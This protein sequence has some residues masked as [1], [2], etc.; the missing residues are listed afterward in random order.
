M[1]A[2]PRIRIKI[3]GIRDAA[4]ARQTALAGA[5]AIGLVFVP[6]TPRYVPSTAQAREIL[7]AL[8]PFCTPVGL[9]V[10]APD[11]LVRETAAATGLT[12][13][14]LHGREGPAYAAD[15]APLRV[16]KAVGFS[17]PETAGQLSQWRHAPANVVGL[18]IDAPPP[19]APDVTTTDIKD[20][21]PPLQ[22]GGHGRTF[23]W[24]GLADMQQRGELAGLPPIILAGGLT[25]TNVAQAI[26]TV[27][28]Y[29]V[30]VSSG[31]ERNKGEK[32]MDLIHQFIDAVNG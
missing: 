1:P 32:D 12:T 14:Q 29:A 28:P 5:D 24:Q 30:D 7:A 3:C 8:P 27:R 11:K 10:D 6:E 16:I 9:F 4:I 26:Q 23:D 15:L 17:G 31:V 2:M 19:Q 20:A 22:T 18:L 13:V 25:P 21:T